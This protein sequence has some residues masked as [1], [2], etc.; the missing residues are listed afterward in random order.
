MSMD[1]S[2][3]SRC[4]VHVP[5]FLGT[6][7]VAGTSWLGDTDLEAES[8]VPCGLLCPFRVPRVSF[9]IDFDRNRCD[10]H[11]QYQFTIL[12]KRVP[13]MHTALAL[14]GRFCS[15]FLQ[16]MARRADPQPF[17]WI[18]RPTDPITSS[19]Q[20]SSI[21][22]P[23]SPPAIAILFTTSSATVRCS[24]GVPDCP[25]CGGIHPGM[26]SDVNLR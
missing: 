1:M 18:D 6:L 15:S 5:R 3:L 25:G 10:S 19:R 23:A 17:N 13:P 4:P 14:M 11:Q 7:H 22:C 9:K 16:Q 8:R 21:T 2:S 12:L 20:I 24:P 26:I